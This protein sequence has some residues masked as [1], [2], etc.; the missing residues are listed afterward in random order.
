M[1]SMRLLRIQGRMAGLLMAARHHLNVVP[2]PGEPEIE[3]KKVRVVLPDRVAG[4]TS[5]AKYS[6]KCF[7][8]DLAKC[9]AFNEIQ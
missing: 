1:P 3:P 8:S 7:Q 2:K 9:L 4:Q 5:P 6:A